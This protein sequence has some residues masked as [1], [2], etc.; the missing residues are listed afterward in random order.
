VQAPCHIN[1]VLT[2]RVYVHDDAA[3]VWIQFIFTG[4]LVYM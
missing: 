3:G 4:I 1:L 2:Q